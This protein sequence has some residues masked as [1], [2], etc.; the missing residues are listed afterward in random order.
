MVA[1]RERPSEMRKA[2]EKPSEL[3]DSRQLLLSD[4]A[5]LERGLSGCSMSWSEKSSPP[6]PPPAFLGEYR[7]PEERTLGTPLGNPASF[8][9]WHT[10]GMR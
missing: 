10:E 1:L 8:V 5:A 9:F 7:G 6:L 3:S 4:S 2:G